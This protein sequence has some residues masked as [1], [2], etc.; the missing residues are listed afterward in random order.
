MSTGNALR[1]AVMVVGIGSHHGDDAVGWRVIAILRDMLETSESSGRYELLTVR[2]PIELM[3][4]LER[5]EV[6]HVVDACRGTEPGRIH[7]WLWPSPELDESRVLGTHDWN[8][9]RALA[10]GAEL[11]WMPGR[12]V[13]WG[14]EASAFEP[15]S[16]T[17]GAVESSIRQVAIRIEG[18]LKGSNSQA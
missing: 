16:E 3:G 12:I 15:M 10:L 7:R 18:E 1:S 2:S 6:L 4:A 14:I 8:L 9:V 5:A 11:A 13:V 17:S